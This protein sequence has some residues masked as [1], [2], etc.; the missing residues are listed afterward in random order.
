MFKHTL[1]HY[2]RPIA[3]NHILSLWQVVCCCEENGIPLYQKPSFLMWGTFFYMIWKVIVVHVIV[4]VFY[5]IKKLIK[6]YPSAGNL[7]LKL[8]D[9]INVEGLLKKLELPAKKVGLILIN[10]KYANKD[11]I[12]KEGDVVQLFPMLKRGIL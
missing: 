8:P 3:D 11:T 9:N 10:G 5:D 4:I 12:L 2:C 1:T 6:K 7:T